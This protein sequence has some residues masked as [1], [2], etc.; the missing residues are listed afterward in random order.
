M[1][2]GARAAPDVKSSRLLDEP[3]ALGAVRPKKPPLSRTTLCL[4]G[5]ACAELSATISD[6]LASVEDASLWSE[7]RVLYRRICL[8]RNLGLGA[9]AAHIEPAVSRAVAAIRDSPEGGGNYDARLKALFA[10]EED[11]VASASVLAE[12]LLPMLREMAVDEA[13]R[14]VCA[15][16]VHS[17]RAADT[18]RRRGSVAAPSIAD[19]I[20]QMI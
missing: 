12:I 2:L 1:P 17:A 5:L 19:F 11:R 10:L 18:G 14:Q 3:Q 15:R 6:S 13:R 7:V 9:E 20:D 8:L 16:P 4:G